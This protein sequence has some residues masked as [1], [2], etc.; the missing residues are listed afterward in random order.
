MTKNNKQ[1]LEAAEDELGDVSAFN[2]PQT[3]TWQFFDEEDIWNESDPIDLAADMLL[4][5]DGVYIGSLLQALGREIY[6]RV[7]SD[8]YI[9]TNNTRQL[10]IQK[11]RAWCKE[12][13]DIM[14]EDRAAGTDATTDH[15]KPS[16]DE[17]VVASL[18]YA[19]QNIAKVLGVKQRKG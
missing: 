19:F 7:D 3:E 14:F 5:G 1:L 13:G 9:D 16:T 2:E 8:H 11:A 17:E 10:I 12:S 6:D 4:D 15:M 18:L